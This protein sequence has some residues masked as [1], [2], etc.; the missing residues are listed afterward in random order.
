[1]QSLTPQTGFFNKVSKVW[2]DVRMEAGCVSRGLESLYRSTKYL[3]QNTPFGLED[4]PPP[5]FPE[6]NIIV[7]DNHSGCRV[8]V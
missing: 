3:T 8:S 4:F 6:A 5:A 2:A 7:V 1:M